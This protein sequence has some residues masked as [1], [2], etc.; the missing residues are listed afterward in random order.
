MSDLDYHRMFGLHITRT[1]GTSLSELATKVL[2]RHDCLLLSA[3]DKLQR[4]HEQLPQERP[5]DRLPLFS[6][7]HYVHESLWGLLLQSSAVFSFTVLRSPLD[8]L[9]S[10]VAHML[11][12]GISPENVRERLLEH[13][14]PTCLEILRCIPIARLVYRNEPLHIQALA[15]LSAF[16]V[17]ESIDRLPVLIDE[18][19]RRWEAPRHQLGH[20]NSAAGH[21]DSSPLDVHELVDLIA[22]D[23]LLWERLQRPD[24]RLPGADIESA[25]RDTYSDQQKS[26]AMFRMHLDDYMR[27]ELDFMGT[28]NEQIDLMRRR[29]DELSRLIARFEQ[30]R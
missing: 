20:L 6:F 4:D 13:P 29:R 2:G 15:A 11:R 25:I 17:V 12:I 14:N 8:R 5:F 19:L 24:W 16:T 27:N 18:L 22:E 9:Q 26:L 10:T 30:L 28:M 3:F 1:A 7:G 23:S 21:K